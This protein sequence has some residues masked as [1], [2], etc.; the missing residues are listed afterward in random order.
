MNR[1]A[2]QRLQDGLAACPTVV[3]VSADRTPA[4][5][6]QLGVSPTAAASGRAGIGGEKTQCELYAGLICR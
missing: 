2:R 6:E 3:T 4:R 5:L 1:L